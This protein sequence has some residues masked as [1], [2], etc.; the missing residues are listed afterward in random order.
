[1]NSDNPKLDFSQRL[2]SVLIERQLPSNKPTWFAREF[3]LRFSG[4]AISVQTA[5]N[6]L[7]G[8]TFPNQEKLLVLAGWLQVS[9]YWLRFG[10]IENSI[11]AQK[12][13]PMQK[14]VF[15]HQRL[16]NLPDKIAR[17]NPQQKQAIDHVIS[18][19]LNEG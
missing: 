4:A 1:M 7:C 5:N 17:L 19:M 3:N 13:L 9:P 11:D 14:N 10:D 16:L 2:K 12:S 8:V 6:W 18:V 15:D